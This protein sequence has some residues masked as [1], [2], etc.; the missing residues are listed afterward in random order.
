MRNSPGFGSRGPRAGLAS[1]DARRRRTCC[2]NYTPK[3]REGKRWGR[4]GARGAHGGEGVGLRD[5]FR[6]LLNHLPDF[7]GNGFRMGLDELA[8]VPDFVLESNQVVFE[9]RSEER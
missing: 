1:R 4:G 8:R 2:G 9:I 7:A 3:I 5:Q 6:P